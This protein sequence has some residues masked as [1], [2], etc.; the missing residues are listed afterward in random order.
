M[1]SPLLLHRAHQALV[2]RL[3]E[4]R[5]LR[6]VGEVLRGHHNTN[7]ILP[8]GIGLALLLG[9]VP[10]ARAKLRVPLKTVEVVPRIWPS[11]AEVLRVVSRHLREV[12]RCLA[13]LGDRSLH[14]YRRGRALSEV[15]PDGDLDDDLMRTFADFF[16]R[17]ARI[18]V[19]EL[20]PRPGNWPDDGDSEGFL[21]WLVDFTENRVHRANREHFGSLFDD[22]L[23]PEGAMARFK[24]N[25]TG[26]TSRPFRLLHTDV[27]RANVVVHN[28]RLA[29]IDWELAI[30]GDPLHEL[31]THVVRMGYGKQD[32]DR[33]TELWAGAMRRAGYG[34]LAAGLDDDLPVYVAF[35]YA[36]SVF[37]DV[38]RAAL[39][40]P[41]RPDDEQFRDAGR[42]ICV[43]IGLAREPLQLMDVPDLER[44]VKALRKWHARNVAVGTLDGGSG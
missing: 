17:T 23:I 24:R 11:E 29:V 36:Q 12:P 32:R 33:M 13:D 39:G 10:F 41:E 22:V 43:A 38:M 26:L 9:T 42:R 15:A 37:P 5:R 31:A 25:H 18:P 20:P 35:E 27:H 7:Y 40:L 19:A 30:Y 14:A 2:H 8:L 3:A 28:R 1:P 34:E 44:T 21:H 4:S 16:V 6:G